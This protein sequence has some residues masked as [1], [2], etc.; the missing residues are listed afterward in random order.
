[1]PTGIHEFISGLGIRTVQPARRQLLSVEVHGPDIGISV[2]TATEHATRIG[3]RSTQ[4]SDGSQITLA[5][6]TVISLVIFS[7]AVVPVKR[8]CGLA[9]LCLGITIRIIGDSMDSSTRQAVE[10][11]Q[12][13]VTTVNTSG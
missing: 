5:T 3:A 2:V 1:M 8:T 6:I 10:D 12:I 9:Q 4:I 11:R 7:T 13:F